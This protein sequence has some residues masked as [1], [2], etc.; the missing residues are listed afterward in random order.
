MF[1]WQFCCSFGNFFSPL[2][3]VILSYY[4]LY[5]RTWV[6]II[7]SVKLAKTVRI[8]EKG[9]CFGGVAR[10]KKEV[11]NMKTKHDNVLFVNGGDFYQGTIWYTK[12]KWTVVAKFANILD[13]TA[14]V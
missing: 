8:V 11:D 7:L 3:V 2:M 12:F 10:L 9:E 1:G 6:E 13:F 14:M 5:G 4:V